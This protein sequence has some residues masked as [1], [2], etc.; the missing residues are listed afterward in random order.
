MVSAMRRFRLLLLLAGGLLLLASG[1]RPAAEPAAPP[2]AEEATTAEPA[3]APL[4]AAPLASAAAASEPPAQ[5]LP[6]QEL[7]AQQ[8]LAPPTPTSQALASEMPAGASAPATAPAGEAFHANPLREGE[9]A[10]L[11]SPPALPEASPAV[12][13]ASP[14]AVLPVAAVGA[15]PVPPKKTFGKGKHSGEKFDPVKVNGEVFADWPKPT[16]ALL[17]SGRQDGY[18]E[19]CGCAGLDR[20]KGGLSRRYSLIEDL[21]QKKGWPLVAVDVG[22]FIKDYGRQAEFKF[23]TT[24]EALRK[25]GYQGIAFGRAE[26]QLPTNELISDVAGVAKEESPFLSANVDFKLIPGLLNRTQIVSAGGKRF[27]LTSVLGRDYQ[28]QINSPDLEITDPQE[29]LTK[30]LPELKGKADVLVLLAYAGEKESE[31]LARQFPEFQVVVTSGGP[32]LPP[33][34]LV[35]VEGTKTL[36]I[37]VAEKAMEVVVLG[38]YDTE[39]TVRYQAVPLDSRYAN[40]EEVRLLMGAYQDNLKMI[41]LEGLGIRP[42][43]GPQKETHGDYVGSAKCEACHTE[44]YKVWKKSGHAKAWNTLEK[45]TPPRDGDPECIACHVIGWNTERFFPYQGGF[46]SAAKTPHLENVGCESC[47]GP[48]SRHVEAEMGGNVE[49][50][51]QLQKT[52]VVTKEE[53]EKH[54]CLSCHDLDN[55][56]DFNFP[57]YWPQVEHHEGQE[58]K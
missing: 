19:P 13:A 26:W 23:H 33:R 9:P 58:Q 31:E 14:P 42:V 4:P 15:E 30:V 37:K 38:F 48:G 21:R 39:P 46:Q 18:L 25:M 10:A 29:A 53:A 1:C 45:A 17:I 5:A 40:S 34:E 8:A 41:G 6:A 2:A 54:L 56:P 55:S 49:L 51:K 3:P 16:V 32:A 28:K 57:D 24:V 43:P 35:T 20:M 47:H 52:M 11:V 36:L 22:G 50:Q 44:S 27:G 7:P 12:S